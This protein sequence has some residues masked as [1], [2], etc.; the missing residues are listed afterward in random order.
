M[1][2]EYTTYQK[3]KY[4]K[5]SKIPVLKGSVNNLTKCGKYA[6]TKKRVNY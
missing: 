3:Q 4:Q 6:K 1:N 2:A 5:S